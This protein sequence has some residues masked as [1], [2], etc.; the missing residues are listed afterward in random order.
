MRDR[1]RSRRRDP[2]KLAWG[3]RQPCYV[4]AGHVCRFR[5][6]NHHVTRERH[7]DLTLSLCGEAHMELHQHGRQTFAAKYGI[8]DLEAAAQA[9]HQRYLDG[10]WSL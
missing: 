3:A 7:D 5:I 1:Y 2:E 4:R 10:E 8:A 9:E 6:Q